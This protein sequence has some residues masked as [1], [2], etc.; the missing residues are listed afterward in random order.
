MR[1]TEPGDAALGA[2]PCSSAREAQL[3][4]LAASTCALDQLARR[5]LGD[6]P[7]RRP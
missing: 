3:D 1:S 6:D 7:A 5:A 2:P 4:D